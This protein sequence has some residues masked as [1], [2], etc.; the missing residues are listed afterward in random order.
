MLYFPNTITKIL[1]IVLCATISMHI[2]FVSSKSISFTDVFSEKS[3][4]NISET[5]YEI[6]LNSV[7]VVLKGKAIE[8]TKTEYLLGLPA[9][10][11]HFF[12]WSYFAIIALLIILAKTQLKDLEND[13]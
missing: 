11:V 8:N 7:P 6:Y 1:L 3:F 13:K 12:Y 10:T 5:H 2:H 9:K 4:H